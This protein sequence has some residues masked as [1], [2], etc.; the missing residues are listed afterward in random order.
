MSSLVQSIEVSHITSN[1]PCRGMVERC[2]LTELLCQVKRINIVRMGETFG[3]VMYPEACA[4][5]GID[6]AKAM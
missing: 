5:V 6:W 2:A 1:I 3:C 4:A